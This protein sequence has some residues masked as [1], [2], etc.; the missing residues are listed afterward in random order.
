[1]SHTRTVVGALALA[2]TT[3]VLTTAS[4]QAATGL[5]AAYGF[6]EGTGAAVADA[7]GTGNNGTTSGTTWA[8]GGR[9]GSALSFNGTNASVTV[10]DSNSLDLVTGMTLEAWVNPKSIG[11]AWRTVAFKQ[12]G[13]GMVYALYANNGAVR[14]VGQVNVVGEQN[15]PGTAQVPLNAW[16]HLAMTYDGATLRLFVNGTQVGSKPQAGGMPASTLPLKLGGNPV[17]GEWFSGLIDEVRVYNRAL[18]AGEI[19]V[20]MT[21][22]VGAS[23]PPT[24]TTP[25]TVQLT[26]PPA[27]SVSGTVGVTAVA[28]DDTSVAG[29][30]LLLDGTALGSEDT[31]APYGVS[32]DT[33][34]ATPGPHTLAARARDAAGNITTSAAVSVNVANGGGSTDPQFVNDRVIIGLDE[35]TQIAWTPDGRMLIAE[36]DGTIWVVPPGSSQVLPTPLIQVPNV[37]TG[38]E[39]GLLGL[40]VDPQ[41]AQNG[42]VYVY[43]THSSLHNRVSRFSVTGDTAAPGSEFVLWQNPSQSAIWHQ[44]GDIRFGPD[45]DLYVSVGDHLQG[46]TAQDLD[47]YNGKIL[48]VTRDGIAPPDNPFY[49]G[50]G[51]NLDAIWAIGLRNPFRFAIDPATGRLIIGDVG[52]GSTEEVDIGAPGANYGWPT[53]EGTC[54]TPGMTNPIYSYPHN[55]RDASVT[56]GFVYRG[57]QF[58]AEY[59]GDF[60]FGDYAQNWIKRLEFNSSGGLGGVQSFEP[61][62]GRLDGPYGDIVAIQQGPDGSLWYVDTGPFQNDNAGSIR[63]VRN[64][65]ANQPPTALASANPTTGQAPLPVA[66]SSAGSADPEG[67][68]ITYRWDFGDG[69]TSTQANPAHTYPT[70]GRYTVRLTTS[71]GTMEA[72]SDP[73]AITA[74]APP[75]PRILAPADGSTFRA[76]D[77]IG[78]SGDATDPEDG[79]I[80]ASRLS[81]KIVFHHDTHIHPVLDGLAG[82]SGSVTIPTTGHSFKGN[83]SYEIVLT[84]TDS[85]GIQASR[86]VTVNPQ[87]VNLTFTS[88]PPGQAVT[89]DSVPSTTPFMVNEIV[90]FQYA[91]DTP[92]P[93]NGNVFSSWSDGG[94]KAHTVTVPATDSTLT[95]RFDTPPPSTGLVAAYGFNEGSGTTVADLSGHNHPGTLSGPAW[96]TAGHA[97]NALSFDGVNDSVTVADHAELRMTNAMTL[98]AWVRPSALGG[99]WRTVLFK[100]QPGQMTYALYANTDTGK[101]TAQAYAGGERDARGTV[102]LP[103]NAWS[104][105]AATYDGTTVKLFVNGVQ[106]ATKAGGGAMATSTRPLKIGGN[107]VF[108]EWFAGL[109][110]DVRVYNRALTATDIQTDLGRPAP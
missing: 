45:G 32:W 94:A 57:S 33:T 31:A 67:A 70:S 10:P 102:A 99:A 89:V 23:P 29:V 4:A 13:G 76:G 38:D 25:P 15:A 24:D 103:V 109:I 79:A 81:W 77:V 14:P 58:P 74:G 2:L 90:G 26:G 3:T 47:S 61:P 92:S 52:E 73:L 84:A 39:R 18:T 59:Q 41:F 60:F 63:R 51:P 107:S 34:T 69:T 66:F 40:T 7:S 62:D 106:A 16:T 37:E 98:E 54:S 55:N 82:S 78:F 86:S 17:W 8:T 11:N 6:N 19:Q 75:A 104:H 91:V 65:N 68:T 105:L 108:G 100:E 30:Q 50:N 9:F 71:D 46:F 72:I 35:P 110:D 85:D 83:T 43:Y 64:V 49:D 80:P 97:G 36:R 96:S 53:C 101:P 28:G 48:R 87:K 27:G 44:G 21:T 93:Q 88:V 42:Y 1:L 95:A 22:A 5:V 56:A 20:D 12:T